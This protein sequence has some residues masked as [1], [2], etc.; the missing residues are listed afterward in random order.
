MNRYWV[1]WWSGYY[2][3]EGC[4]EPP[5]QIWTSGQ[6][7]RNTYDDRDECSL[8]AVIDSSSEEIIWEAIS[9]YFPDYEERFCK[10]VE[11]NYIPG[12]RFPGFKN[13]TLL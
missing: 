11:N 9:K 2:A 8:C 3:D 12:D 5:F 1:S 13:K 4:T 6:R 10:Q 7:N